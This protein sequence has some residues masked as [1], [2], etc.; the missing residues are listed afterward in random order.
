MTDRSTKTNELLTNGDGVDFALYLNGAV[1]AP[2]DVDCLF[3]FRLA[4][5]QVS[6]VLLVLLDTHIRAQCPTQRTKHQSSDEKFFRSA[7]AQQLQETCNH[8]SNEKTN[9]L[10]LVSNALNAQKPT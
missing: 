3:H 1:F 2:V 5:H 4:D 6:V 7:N 10:K 8:K 9:R